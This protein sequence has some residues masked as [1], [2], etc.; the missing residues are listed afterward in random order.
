MALVVVPSARY[1]K[2]FEETLGTIEA[3]H[4]NSRRQIRSAWFACPAVLSSMRF[5]FEESRHA[6]QTNS[7]SRPCWRY[8]GCGVC[9][10]ERRAYT[11]SGSDHRFAGTHS[12]LLELIDESQRAA[13]LPEEVIASLRKLR[14][15][16][17][18]YGVG[19]NLRAIQQRV[20]RDALLR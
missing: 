11:G 4:S 13:L 17:L 10:S 20:E 14:S 8:I 6:A 16:S 1:R 19:K 9:F 15:L 7:R 2:L 5:R 3:Q 18:E 12:A